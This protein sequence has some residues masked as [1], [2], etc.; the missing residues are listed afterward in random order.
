MPTWEGSGRKWDSAY[1][2][3]EW[4]EVGQCLPGKGVGGS[5][6]VPTWE[7]SGRKWDSAYLGREWE[8]VG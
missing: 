7:G 2:G 8:E 1:L 6:T 3:R 5:G 4:E